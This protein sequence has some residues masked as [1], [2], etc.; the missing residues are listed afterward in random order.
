M[1]PSCCI[2]YLFDWPFSDLRRFLFVRV[3]SPPHAAAAVSL[4]CSTFLYSQLRS[5]SRDPIA[6]IL[7]NQLLE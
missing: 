4:R 6:G 2:R 3:G 1:L 7:S 5:C